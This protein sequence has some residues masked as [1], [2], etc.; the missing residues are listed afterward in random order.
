MK[1]VILAA[2]R[3]TRLGSLTREVPKPML[4]VAG[5][6]M[7]AWIVEGLRAAGVSGI[8]VVTGYL[9]DRIREHFGESLSYLEQPQPNGTGGALQL[10]EGLVDGAFFVCFG[11]I[12]L[13]PASHYAGIARMFIREQPQAVLAANRVEDPCVGA[14]VYFDDC[15]RIARVVEKPAP[16]QSATNYNQ[17]GC[18]VFSPDVFDALRQIKPGPRGE[19][20]LTA[21]VN[22]MLERGE[23]L[24]AYPVPEQ[25]WIDIG[26]PE[27]LEAARRTLQ[28]EPG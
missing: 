21:A 11:D 13:H 7:L 23:R 18:F 4:D 15:L 26:T 25:D 10:A 3:G 2:G 1:A 27:L 28:T 8:Y 6:P 9:G 20:E 22:L 5:K 12:L 17:A 16:G 19:L 24:M 14:A